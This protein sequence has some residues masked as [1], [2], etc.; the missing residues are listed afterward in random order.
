MAPSALNNLRAGGGVKSNLATLL[1]PGAA[2]A[3]PGPASALSVSVGA[4]ASRPRQSKGGKGGADEPYRSLTLGTPF[5]FMDSGDC[6]VKASYFVFFPS[7][8]QSTE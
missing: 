6:N 4:A 3:G 5:L 2:S 1:P 7:Q 8:P